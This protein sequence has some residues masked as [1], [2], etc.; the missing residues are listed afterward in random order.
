MIIN[1]FVMNKIFEKFKI[2]IGLILS[3]VLIASSVILLYN[4]NQVQKI[5]QQKN[6]SAEVDLENLKKENEYLKNQLELIQNQNIESNS[7][8]KTTSGVSVN[9]STKVDSQVSKSTSSLIN[10]NSASNARLDTLPGIGATK[11]QAV[12]DYRNSSGKFTKID[13][14][15][16]VSGIGQATFDKIK[17]LITVD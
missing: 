13:D 10:I 14:I 6:I 12:I 7:V 3:F 2:Q 17:S 4:Q 8:V 9:P 5:N 11:A 15:M 16:K 1:I